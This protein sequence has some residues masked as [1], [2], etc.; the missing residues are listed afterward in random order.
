MRTYKQELEFIANDILN[1]NAMAVGNENI[2]GYSN[3]DFMNALIIFQNALMDKMFESME[4][5]NM[6]L[7]DRCKMA[8]SCGEDLKKLIF[9]YTNLDT[10][11]IE[12]FL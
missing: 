2:P 7:E 10:K 3:R 9:T 8:V 1:Q 4:Y 5:D 11:K 6:D 12:D